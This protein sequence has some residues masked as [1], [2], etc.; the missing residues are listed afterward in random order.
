MGVFSRWL[1]I[2]A[3]TQT[4]APQVMAQAAQSERTDIYIRRLAGLPAE[5]A[6]GQIKIIDVGHGPLDTMLSIVANRTDKGW[7]VSYACASSPHCGPNQDHRAM[8]YVLS[9]QDGAAVDAIL[10][11][12]EKGVEPEGQLSSP[13]FIG[14][15]L[16][17]SIDDRGFKRDYRR[18]GRWGQTLGKLETLLSPPAG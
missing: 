5:S 7:S 10:E 16:L 12:L 11:E 4:L 8:F 9:G 15:D 18:S 2:G 13:A 17:V 1:L 3:V 6:N 14:G